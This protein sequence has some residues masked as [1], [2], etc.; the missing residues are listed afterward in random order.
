MGESSVRKELK[1]AGAGCAMGVAC[2]R[3]HARELPVLRKWLT[4]SQMAE[5]RFDH[6]VP[7]LVDEEDAETLAALEEGIAQLNSGQGIAL[8]ELRRELAGRCAE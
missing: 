2:E 4:L 8:Q 3:V 6:P 7:T 1:R 5:S